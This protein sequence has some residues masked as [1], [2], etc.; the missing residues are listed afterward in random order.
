MISSK[1]LVSLCTDFG[2]QDYKLALLKLEILKYNSSINLIDITHEIPSFDL[3]EAAFHISNTIVSFPPQQIHVIWVLNASDD[4]GIIL[5]VINDQYLIMPNNGILGLIST[6]D[7]IEKVYRIS[8]DAID[9]K[10]RIAK[11]IQHINSEDNLDNIFSE[12]I[13][14]IKKINVQPVYLKDRIQARVLNI[15]R[16]GNLILNILLNPFKEVCQDRKFSFSTQ[17]QHVISNFFLDE[18]NLENGSFYVYFT[19]AGYMVLALC[20]DKA[21]RILDILKGDSLFIVFE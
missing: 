17:N 5:A 21:S 6:E 14:P 4:Q 18:I 9:Y 11:T 10:E 2:L 12:L 8:D 1:K 3:V 7:V 16:Y 20:G 19:E 13:D 15:D